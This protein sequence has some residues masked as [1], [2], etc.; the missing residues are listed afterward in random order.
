LLYTTP[1]NPGGTTISVSRTAGNNG[2][3]FNGE[4]GGRRFDMAVSLADC[5]DGMSE[6]TYPFTVTLSFGAEQRGGCG[7]TAA[8]PFRAAA[9]SGDASPH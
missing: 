6:R 4:M 7:W 9:P 1:E 5:S 3:G 8:R 2:L